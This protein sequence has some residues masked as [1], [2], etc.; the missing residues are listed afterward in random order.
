MASKIVINTVIIGGGHAGVNLGCWLEKEDPTRDYVI[1]E[2]QDTLL[3]QWKYARWDSFQLNTP[4]R[5]STLYG[6]DVAG[7]ETLDRP[8]Q[9]DLDRWTAH[10]DKTKIKHQLRASVDKVVKTTEGEFETLVTVKKPNNGE[11]E[12]L[13]YLSKNVVCANGCYNAPK[14]IVDQDLAKKHPEIKQF[15]PMGL[16]LSDLQSGGV[17]IVGGGQTGVQ[18]ADLLLEEKKHAPIALCTSKVKGCPRSYRG[19][20]LFHW[21]EKAKFLTLPKEA[22]KNMPPE[23]AEGLR[24]GLLPI[25][26]AK[27]PISYFSLHRQGVKLLGRLASLEADNNN[28]CQAMLES[29]LGENIKRSFDGYKGL[30]DILTDTANKWKHPCWLFF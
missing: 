30:F 20:D 11:E 19:K 29:N 27:K 24:Y 25:V 15:S 22:L 13:V 8:L 5:F 10:M 9:Q 26:G 23:K 1:L 6:E 2:K 7:D 4:V 28:G 3:P 18:L 14:K 16:K 17:L 21:L 12:K